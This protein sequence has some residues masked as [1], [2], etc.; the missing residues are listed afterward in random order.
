[1]E[2]SEA[3]RLCEEWLP[4]WTGNRPE[5]LA[6]L[7]TEDTFYRDPAVPGGISG[8]PGLL[9]YFEKLCAFSPN[10]VW[11]ADDVFP[12]DG[13][14]VLRW[15]AEIPIG[16]EIIRETGMDLVLVEGGRISRNEVYFDRA[17]LMEALKRTV[18]S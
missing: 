1:M 11:K 15:N 3:L 7:Y 9:R 5:E 12:I 2:K 4:L 8:K 13:G 16:T 18:K 6:G 10:W 17:G 14:F